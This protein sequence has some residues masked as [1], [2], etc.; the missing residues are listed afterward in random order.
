[1]K[2]ESVKIDRGYTFDADR[3]LK[4][5]IVF[6][7]EDKTEIKMVLDEQLAVEIVNLCADAIARAGQDAA[8]AIT[9]ETLAIPALEQTG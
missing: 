9:A 8:K 5:T 4:G 7:G 2:V 3:R 6:M 1:M